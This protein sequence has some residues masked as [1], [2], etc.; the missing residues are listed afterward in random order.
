MGHRLFMTRRRSLPC[1][2]RRPRVKPTI[3]DIRR[4]ARLALHTHAFE[5]FTTPFSRHL[6]LSRILL[7]KLPLSFLHTN[8]YEAFYALQRRPF[9]AMISE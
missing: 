5:D 7:S 3:A 6:P 9:L 8:T 2:R 4:A 1:R